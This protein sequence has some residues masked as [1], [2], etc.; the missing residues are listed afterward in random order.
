MQ[1][2]EQQIQIHILLDPFRDC[3][4]DFPMTF[5]DQFHVFGLEAGVADA[6]LE[7]FDEGGSDVGVVG[8]VQNL[9][10]QHVEGTDQLV[11]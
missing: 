2:Q 11:S 8:T 10:S 6:V 9:H 4:D 5:H 7:E 1:F 3:S